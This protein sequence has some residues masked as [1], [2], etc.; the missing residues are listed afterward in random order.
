MRKII[1][2]D[3][4][5]TII[6]YDDLFLNLARQLKFISSRSILG[7]KA[8]RDQI[9]SQKNGEEKWQEL[10][11]I[12]YTEL[13]GRAKLF[14]GVR[15]FFKKCRQNNFR[16]FIVSHKTNYIYHKSQ[17]YDIC[18]LALNW[19]TMHKFFENPAHFSSRHVFFEASREMK[20]KRIK[21]LQCTHFIDDLEETFANAN[22]PDNVIKML[23]DHH[24]HYKKVKGIRIFHHWKEINDYFF[25]E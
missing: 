19:L 5:N 13:V 6:N 11:K 18:E 22:F 24:N 2:V 10:Q 20:S 14:E 4:D 3:L 21:I 12:I 1:G 17:K 25:R 7:K 23:M 15:K 8:I 9:R 16:I